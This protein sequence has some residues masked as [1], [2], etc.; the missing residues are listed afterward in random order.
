MI[1]FF[2]QRVLMMPYIFD[3]SN[4]KLFCFLPLL[5]SI[6][7]QLSHISETFLALCFC[8]LLAQRLI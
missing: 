5:V 3:E 7:G 8:L 2:I 1:G 4:Q 6:S